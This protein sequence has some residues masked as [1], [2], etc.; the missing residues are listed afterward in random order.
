[1]NGIVNFNAS[2]HQNKKAYGIVLSKDVGTDNYRSRIGF[3]LHP[4]PFGKYTIVFEF[5][6]PEMTNIKL[7]CQATDSYIHKV[8]QRD[9]IDYSKLLIQFNH[10]SHL[11]L[12]YIYFT[13]HGTAT[14]T[15]VNC[16]LIVYGE[17]DWSDSVHPDVCN[18][19]LFE[20]YEN[21]D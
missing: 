13:M 21:A 5:F 4:I 17:K 11:A 10:I 19:S 12:D 3:N 9:F 1:M 8:V 15:P 14:A 6:P 16:H 7:S 2:P 18:I 20:R